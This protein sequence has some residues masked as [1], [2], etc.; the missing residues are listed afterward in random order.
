[1]NLHAHVHTRDR[2]YAL[3]PK[4]GLCHKFTIKVSESDR[5]CDACLKATTKNMAY[6]YM[7]KKKKKST[8]MLLVKQ[9]LN[10]LKVRTKYPYFL[11]LTSKK[12]YVN[13][14]SAQAQITRIHNVNTV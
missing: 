4:F 8:N 3:R 10:M 11:K 1:M 9:N 2:F 5:C 14:F 12:F 6:Y 7:Q 13:P